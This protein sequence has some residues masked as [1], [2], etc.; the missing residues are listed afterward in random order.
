MYMTIKQIIVGTLLSATAFGTMLERL[1][2]A[3]EPAEI[4]PVARHSTRAAT[5]V[6]HRPHHK[7]SV[8]ARLSLNKIFE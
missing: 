5:R 7:H 3:S 2:N 6:A 4:K 8:E 1:P